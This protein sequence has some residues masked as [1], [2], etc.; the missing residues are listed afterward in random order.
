MIRITD[1][2]VSFEKKEY[3]HYS[4]TALRLDL[5]MQIALIQPNSVVTTRGR[6][7]V[8]PGINVKL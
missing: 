3:R 7:V 2:G 8:S 4:H 5:S 6:E 1:Y